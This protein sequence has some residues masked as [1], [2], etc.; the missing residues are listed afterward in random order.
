MT[1]ARPTIFLGCDHGGLELK[2]HLKGLLERQGYPV[3]DFGTHTPDAV[4]YPDIAYLV[5]RSV[6]EARA[7]G[8]EA[9]GIMIDGVGVASSMVCNRVPGIRSA[10][11]WNEFSA[12]SAREH[13][14]ANVITLGGRLHGVALA[15]ALVI[16]F[17]ETPYAGGRHQRRVDKIHLL[18]G[19]PPSGAR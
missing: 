11:C 12:R 10:P 18:A 6:A 5:A 19:E 17:L 8:R 4:D 1:E 15:E 7:G 16:T 9:F 13:N 2:E 3:K 14:N